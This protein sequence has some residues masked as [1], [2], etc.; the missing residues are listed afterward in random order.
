[1]ESSLKEELD[2]FFKPESIVLVGFSRSVGAISTN[3]LIN[4]KSSGYEGDVFVC[5]RNVAAGER[6][7]GV[8]NYPKVGLIPKKVDLAILTVPPHVLIE[9]IEE[10]AAAGVRAAICITSGFGE[11]GDEGRKRQEELVRVA[12]RG[13]LRIIGPNCNGLFSAEAKLAAMLAPVRPTPGSVGVVTQGGTPGVMMVN[14]SKKYAPIVGFSKCVN[15]GDTADV[16]PHEI[17]EYY[18]EDPSIK[19]IACYFEGLRDG[20]KFVEIA[21]RITPKKPII[22]YKAGTSEAGKQ[23][24]SSHVGALAGDERVYEAALKQAGVL[25]VSNINDLVDATAALVTQ[26]L[27]K[28]RNVG[29]LTFGGGGGVMATD[30][31]ERLGLKVPQISKELVETF[32]E[33]LPP[34][35]SHRNP[36][37][38]TD[39]FADLRVP[40]K[41]AELL[42]KEDYIDMLLVIGVG[43]LE[44]VDVGENLPPELK[45]VGEKLKALTIGFESHVG[46]ALLG[47]RERYKKP[48]IG[49][50]ICGERDGSSIKAFQK[51]GVPVYDSPDR[52]A[53]ALW[54][55]W[56]YKQFVDRH[57]NQSGT[58]NLRTTRH[59]K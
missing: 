18:G 24:A 38:M 59:G 27:P 30:E 22:F 41:C 12:R 26:P 31:L 20:R 50:M 49:C 58:R 43:V 17:L 51:S 57:K 29:I 47:L 48:I 55:L 6:I 36:V 16:Q 21:A 33:M 39:G 35:W 5:N 40:P 32:N 34:Y 46:K 2:A 3:V 15:L 4:I 13:G 45:K 19:V 52:A 37:D 56:T 11:T 28:G 9:A 7:F 54:A 10:C 42:L 8:E 23:A 14:L 1:M 53:R 44:G 25:Q